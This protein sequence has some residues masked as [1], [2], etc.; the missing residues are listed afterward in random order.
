MLPNPTV[1]QRPPT[2][3]EWKAARQP[4]ETGLKVMRKVA[5]KRLEANGRTTEE[6]ITPDA[7]E[8]LAR[9]SGGVMRGFV[10][11]VHEAAT[12]ALLHKQERID[13]PLARG[14]IDRQHQ[15]IAIQLDLKHR[16]VLRS[17]LE[18]GVLTGRQ[19]EIEEALLRGNYLLSYKDEEANAWLDA[20]PNILPLL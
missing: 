15:N 5:T 12:A 6:V 13:L 16:E 1:H 19:R 9:M 17:V 3:S 20:H 10:R 4:N 11:S 8:L 18:H 14:V 2:R 7:L